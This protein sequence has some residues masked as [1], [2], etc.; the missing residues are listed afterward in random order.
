M[1]K[2][3]HNGQLSTGETMTISSVGDVNTRAVSI[4]RGNYILT[5]GFEVNR[6]NAF[7]NNTQDLSIDYGHAFF[8]TTERN[9]V[10][11]FFSFGPKS[12]A[13]QG[14]L[15]NEFNG[16]RKATTEYPIT[17]TT[18][19]F[20][21]FITDEQL[22]K[23]KSSADN[24]TAKVNHGEEAYN[25]SL[26]DTCAETARDILTEG[27]VT[28]PDGTGAITGTNSEI[29]NALGRIGFVNPYMWFH[30]FVIKYGIPI[31]YN[32]PGGSTSLLS[33]T[34]GLF[35]MVTPDWIL[36]TGDPDPLTSPE[37]STPVHDNYRGNK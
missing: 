3:R 36:S 25:A 7:S 28:T 29:G 23:I 17:E 8:Y 32:G 24:F 22:G 4:T 13:S 12:L 5:I 14:K 27:G 9:L 15:T 26:N 18:K 35:I 20:R 33:S 34:D 1:E 11:T 19:L 31:D 2:E 6:P 10:V 16:P 30:N 37:S 21:F